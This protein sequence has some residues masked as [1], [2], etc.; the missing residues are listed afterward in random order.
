MEVEYSKHS[1]RPFLYLP[2]A[3]P[4]ENGKMEIVDNW[5]AMMIVCPICNV[6]SMHSEGVK[7]F[8]CGACKEESPVYEGWK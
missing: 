7:T 6:L 5:F 2:F 1:G 3:M 8:I 4:Q